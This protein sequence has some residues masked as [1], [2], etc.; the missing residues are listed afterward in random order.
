MDVLSAKGIL[1]RLL[2][3]FVVFLLQW[4]GLLCRPKQ[5]P[6]DKIYKF[7]RRQPPDLSVGLPKS[8]CFELVQ[9]LLLRSRSHLTVIPAAAVFRL[10]SKFAL[11]F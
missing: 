7:M 3:F 4:F 11:V 8:V 6:Y 1:I 5:A 2:F 10:I 9:S